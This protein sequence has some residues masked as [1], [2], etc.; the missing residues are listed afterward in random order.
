MHMW[1][2]IKGWLMGALTLGL[3]TLRGPLCTR[4]SRELES[5]SPTSGQ[6]GSSWVTG[7][8]WKPSLTSTRSNLNSRAVRKG[9]P[10]FHHCCIPGE[11]TSPSVGMPHPK[12]SKWWWIES[13]LVTSDQLQVPSISPSRWNTT[14][15]KVQPPLYHGPASLFAFSGSPAFYWRCVGAVPS[16]N[17]WGLSSRCSWVP[18]VL[19]CRSWSLR[20]SLVPCGS[21]H[22]SYS[23][24]RYPVLDETWTRPRAA[25]VH[26]KSLVQGFPGVFGHP[27]LRGTSQANG[28]PEWQKFRRS[29]IYWGWQNPPRIWDLHSNL[30]R[31]REEH[32]FGVSVTPRASA[33]PA[34]VCRF[35]GTAGSFP[36]AGTS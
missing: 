11:P 26:R 14:P 5:L 32:G 9:P 25:H 6:E 33:G 36:V 7:K 30:N 4:S 13:H 8:C 22:C 18:G 12:L 19:N 28:V 23:V 3:F 31:C 24:W 20:G 35:Q 10:P 1:D 21:E 16:A 34:D 15:V 2:I 17:M 27:H 29:L